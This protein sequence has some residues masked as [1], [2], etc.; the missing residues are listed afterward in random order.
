MMLWQLKTPAKS[1]LFATTDSIS[2]T[3]LEKSKDK[4]PYDIVV[5]KVIHNSY[6][7]HENYLTLN[8][9]AL[10]GVESD[11]GVINNLG[12]VGIIEILRQDI[13]LLLVF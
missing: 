10:Q 1:V 9:V 4:Q 13:P 5:S 7:V 2:I 11:M 8:S 6:N 12:L 3:K